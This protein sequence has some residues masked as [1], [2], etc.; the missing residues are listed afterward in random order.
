MGHRRARVRFVVFDLDGTLVDSQRDI[1]NAANALVEELGGERLPMDAIAG[2]VGEG[3][4]LLVRRALAAASLDPDVPGALD[5]FLALY[6][7][8]LLDHTR[9][10]EGVER[11]LDEVGRRL[12]LAILTNKPARASETIIFGLCLRDRFAHLLGGDSAFGRKPDPAGLLELVSRAGVTPGS[13]MLVGDSTIDLQ[14]ARNAGAQICLARYGFGF[15]HPGPDL[16]PGEL[17]IDSPLQLL[18]VLA[19]VGRA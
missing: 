7:E 12:P 11:V 8:R 13:T 3:A 19:P 9:P 6:G 15:Q 10:Y 18:E 2:M 17:A 14:T 16:R 4:G 5:R 1:A